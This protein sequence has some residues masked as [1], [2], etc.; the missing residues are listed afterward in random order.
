M[1]LNVWYTLAGTLVVALA[2]G[3]GT[4][5][6]KA[7]PAAAADD[8]KPPARQADEDAIRQRSAEFMRALEKGDARAVAAFWTEEG[9]YVADDGTTLRGRAA[10]EKAY[11]RFLADNTKLKATGE[12]DS[13]RFISRDS[14]VEEGHARVHSAKA[15]HPALNRYSTLYA[16]EDGRWQIALLRVWP[17]EG[18]SLRDLDWL[19]GTWASKTPLA[20][21]R[22][23]YEWNADKTFIKVR[24]S[25]KTPLQTVAGTQVIGKDPRTGQLR[26]W[27]FEDD[28][29]FGDAEWAR[30]GKRWVLTATGVEEDG[31]EITATNI[32]T[33]LDK[34]SFTWQSVNREADGED[35]PDLPPIKVT[36]VK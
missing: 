2:V 11:T 20:E 13:I 18:V 22:T 29:G 1:K 25:V 12:I 34:D 19:I 4:A 8:T 24:F 7:A 31:T 27:L 3:F 32:M 30:D 21:V 14:A 16:R 15:D 9:E 6:N 23:T 28:G 10:I 17:D 33:P 26:S 36:R 5:P 35:L